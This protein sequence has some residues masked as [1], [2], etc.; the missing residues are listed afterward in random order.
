MT[1]RT[2]CRE[3]RRARICAASRDGLRDEML[4][5]AIL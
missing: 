4:G 3:D 1:I 5:L 2:P